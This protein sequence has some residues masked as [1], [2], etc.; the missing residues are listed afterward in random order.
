M[1]VGN[2]YHPQDGLWVHMCVGP[3]AYSSSLILQDVLIT[4]YHQTLL[5]GDTTPYC[6]SIPQSALTDVDSL[7]LSINLW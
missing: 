4:G 3:S 7:R 5:S 6:I 2:G 1:H